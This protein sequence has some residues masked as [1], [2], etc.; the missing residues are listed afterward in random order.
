MVYSGPYSAL[1][2]FFCPLTFELILVIHWLSSAFMGKAELG[3]NRLCL[4]FFSQI[5][6]RN[7]YTSC[8]A[9]LLFLVQL[10]VKN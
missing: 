8:F 1:R 9:Q 6:L 7:T 2:G 5:L 4:A 3:R 10:V